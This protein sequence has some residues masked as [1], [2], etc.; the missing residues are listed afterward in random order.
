MKKLKIFLYHLLVFILGSAGI[1]VYVFSRLAS[2]SSGAGLGGIIVMPA[3]ITVYIAAF[4]FLCT[5]SFVT[6][7]LIVYFR[8]RNK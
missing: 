6:W 2:P 4:G 3:I 7:L 5:I 1:V 8:S